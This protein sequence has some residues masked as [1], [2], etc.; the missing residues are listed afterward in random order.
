MIWI[1]GKRIETFKFPNGETGIKGEQIYDALTDGINYVVFKY[2]SDADLIELMFV[3]RHIDTYAGVVVGLRILYMPYSRMDRQNDFHTVF[4]LKHVAEF[5]NW[6]GFDH[7]DVDEP[8]SDVTCAVLNN[9]QPQ[10]LTKRLISNVMDKIGFDPERDY[11]FYPDAG[12][13]KRYSDVTGFKTLVGHKH[14]DFNTGE[15]KSLQVVGSEQIN[16]RDSSFKVLIVDDL[17]SRGGTFMA[18]GTELRNLGATE[19]YLLTA[20]C[21]N[22]IHNGDIIK[23]DVINKVFTT[24]S[25]LSPCGEVDKIHVFTVGGTI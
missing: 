5:I 2:E 7:I 15:I 6:L 14:R 21:E 20:H 17:C 9:A 4:T 24:D 18:A 12:A 13:A 16:D 25:I 19:V 8:H 22:T 23:T 1:N 10:Y 11:V 3:K